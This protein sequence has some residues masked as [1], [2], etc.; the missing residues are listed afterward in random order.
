MAGLI[1][2]A[3]WKCL[4]S[5]S[6]ALIVSWLCPALLHFG[7]SGFQALVVFSFYIYCVVALF[8]FSPHKLFHVLSIPVFTQFLHLFQKYAFPAGANS[9]WRLLPFLILDTYLINFFVRSA[10]KL[11]RKEQLFLVSWTGS[12][13]FFLCISPN[14]GNV[15][16]GATVLTLVTL[17]CYLVYL[18]A[19][20]QSS[21]FRARLES[22]LCLLYIILGAGTF[23]LVAA[24]ASYKGSDNLLATRNITDTNVTMAYFVLL[25]PF[26][27]LYARRQRSRA[28]LVI[29]LTSVFL[30]VV[31]F[32]FSR[33][34][35]L[36][37]IPYLI[38]T[39]TFSFGRWLF[40]MFA[41]VLGLLI[42]TVPWTAPATDNAGL[43]YFWKLRFGDLA[44]H[45][46]F[47]R[48]LETSG[49]GEIH[50][51]AHSLFLESPVFGHGTGS[52]EVLGPGYR[53]A[54]SLWYT[55]MAENGLIGAI[56]MYSVFVQCGT[57][58]VSAS[59]A[60]R[61]YKVLPLALV[62]YLVFNHTVGSVFVIIPAKSLT[63]NCIAPV[64][65]LCLYFYSES[66]R[67]SPLSNA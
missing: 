35:V 23:G 18:S 19:A 4:L 32:S 46:I 11:N 50:A 33:G 41:G 28:G 9:L 5:L 6:I 66:L 55:L 27:L 12:N 44:T 67:K 8:T 48:L 3:G 61:M 10:C 45:S 58:L 62:V 60:G 13:V 34:A 21:D 36:L 2:E 65:L 56:L 25:W 37:I 47:G 15:V 17:P 26:A 29:F 24:G 14:L 22:Y 52:F 16:F 30:G 43:T 63:I 53:E 39:N 57:M 54:H 51:V 1:A 31:L 7:E 42:L 40:W 59:N 64:L 49:R 38:I 20:M